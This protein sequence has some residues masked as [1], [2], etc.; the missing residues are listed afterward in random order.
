[1]NARGHV[2]IQGG[3]GPSD[4]TNNGDTGIIV[5]PG[6]N[7]IIENNIVEDSGTGYHLEAS[8]AAD[9]NQLYGNLSINT[10]N[11]VVIRTRDA[12][13]AN[14]T[15]RNHVVLNPGAVGIYLRDAEN[16][17]VFNSSVFS[18]STND[19]FLCDDVSAGSVSSTKPSCYITNSLSYGNASHG[20]R[21]TGQSAFGFNYT[22]SM[23]NAINY[24]PASH[25][26]ITNRFTAADA[27]V[28]TK[29]WIPETSSL[30]RSGLNG[31]DIGANILYRYKNGEETSEPLWSPVSGAFPCGV[32][33]AGVNDAS[34]SSCFDVHVRLNVNPTTLPSAYGA[35]PLAAPTNSRTTKSDP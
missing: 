32:V 1:L 16:T 6:S 10:R 31:S 18:S 30:K 14:N 5:Y 9:G 15:I 19:G 28:G 34:G 12:L 25:K 4:P 27:N 24:A 13:A 20:M 11:G 23:K 22:A 17:Q 3:Y 2:D 21:Q 7:N 8:S 26:S 33:I 35:L 29:I